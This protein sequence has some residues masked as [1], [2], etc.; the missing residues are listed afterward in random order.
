MSRLENIARSAMGGDSIMDGRENIKTDD[1]VQLYPNGI[2]ITGV[3]K[4][5]YNGSTYPVFTFAE[6][7]SKYFSGATALTQLVDGMLEGYDGNWA[8]LNAD[9]QKEYLK[10]K[11]VKTKT[12]RGYNFTKVIV[13]GVVTAPSTVTDENGATIDTETGEVISDGAEVE[14]HDSLPF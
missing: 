4:N 7:P 1:I 3:A 9:L 2:C 12:K 8:A 14:S 10:I 5:T 11:L 6:D 13:V